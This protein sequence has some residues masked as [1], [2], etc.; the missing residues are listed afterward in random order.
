MAKPSRT[1]STRKAPSKGRPA[2]KKQALSPAILLGLLAAALLVVAGIVILA[3]RAANA[4][5]VATERVGEGT[6]WGPADAP[7]QIVDFSDFGCSHCSNF[8]L[9]QGKQLRAEYEATGKVRFEYKHMIINGQPTRDAANAAECAADQGRFWDY[10]D[11]LFTRAGTTANP[12]TKPL[13][14]R[15]AAELGLDSATF[16][17][18]VDGDLHSATVA[19]TESEARSKGINATPTFFINGKKIEGA[20]PYAQFKA[21]VDAALAVA[22]Q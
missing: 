8:G 13:L 22:Q 17:A 12:F 9:N 16:D 4:P 5:L 21:E 20:L 2:P 11:A 18:C 6:A 15:Y 14:K 7:V 19:A 3:V 1:T 10:H